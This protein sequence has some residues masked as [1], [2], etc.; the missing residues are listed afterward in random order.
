MPTTP[1]SFFPAGTEVAEIAAELAHRPS[2]PSLV[3]H[4]VYSEEIRQRLNAIQPETMFAEER[5][6]E[7]R[8]AMAVLA[9]L[10]LWNDDLAEC[11]TIAQG[12][13]TPTGSYWH[14]LMHRREPDYENAKYWFR[15]VGEHPVFAELYQIAPEIMEAYEDVWSAKT[16]AWLRSHGRWDAITMVDWCREVEEDHPEEGYG[17]VEEIQMREIELLLHHSFRGAVGG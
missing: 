5:I 11:H 17:V 15:R 12:I 3:A 13:E 1:L 2:K 8:D 4:S 7:P 16:A 10:H 9:G 6:V 14:G